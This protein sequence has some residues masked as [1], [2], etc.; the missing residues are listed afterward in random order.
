VT[1]ADT[2][3]LDCAYK[4]EEYAGR[5]RRKRSPGRQTLPG[6]KQVFRTYDAS[7]QMRRDV[8]ELCDRVG[9]G[10]PLLSEA[11]RGGQRIGP[12]E[13]LA[14]IRGRLSQQLP[15]LPRLLQSLERAEPYPVVLGTALAELV[16]AMERSGS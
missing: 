4:L 7:G 1:S 5:P 2:P 11:M 12:P 3:A 10:E 6:R 9:E 13:P 16:C 15:K 8:V 14:A